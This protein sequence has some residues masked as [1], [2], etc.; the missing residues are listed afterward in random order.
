M[1]AHAVEAALELQDLVAAAIRASDPH[2][3]R[4]RLGPRRHE[5][6]LFRTRDG[7]DQFGG[8]ADAVF[9]VGEKSEA[10]VK[11]FAHRRHHIRIP[12]AD[13]HR[14]RPEQ[15][16]DVLTAIDIGHAASMTL[17]NDD[18][19]GKIAKTA[20]WQHAACGFHHCLRGRVH[21]PVSVWLRR[22]T[23][24]TP[25]RLAQVARPVVIPAQAGI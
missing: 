2:R 20:G 1:V 19:A 24:P 17:A 21:H 14:A 16:I 22:G 13:E 25:V 18:V 5:A 3:E 10:A 6:D 4:I 11:L 9:V 12:V 8:E 7:I 15:K 23:F